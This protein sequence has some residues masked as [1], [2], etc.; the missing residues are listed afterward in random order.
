MAK[1]HDP[2]PTRVFTPGSPWFY[3][4]LYAQPGTLDE[5]LGHSLHPMLESVVRCGICDKWFFIRYGDPHWHLRLRFHGRAERLY[6][7]LLPNLHDL[8]TREMQQRR[9]WRVSLDTYEQEVERYGGA[10][11]MALAE[12]YFCADSAA[13]IRIL[14]DRDGAARLDERW[15]WAM[16]GIHQMLDDFA[17]TAEQKS[18]LLSHLYAGFSAEFR[19]N[20]GVIKALSDRFRCER[21]QLQECLGGGAKGPTSVAEQAFAERTQ[22][23]RAIISELRSIHDTPRQRHIL[24]KVV[25]SLIHMQVNRLLRCAHRKQELVMYCMLDKLYHSRLAQQ[26]KRS[27]A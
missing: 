8:L 7:G 23:T 12:D 20:K 16:L 15:R 22:S 26:Q 2:Q 10:R 25:G 13:M 24:N 6:S 9:I 18:Q 14:H 19:V 21:P 17:Y 27:A 4:K 1:D 5:L 11:S 3:V